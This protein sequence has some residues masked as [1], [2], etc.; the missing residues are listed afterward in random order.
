MNIYIYTLFT[1]FWTYVVF[2]FFCALICQ[3]AAIIQ[4]FF[5]VTPSAT[6]THY[7]YCFEYLNYAFH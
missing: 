2:I 6:Y 3:F 5:L 4:A 1:V 7:L